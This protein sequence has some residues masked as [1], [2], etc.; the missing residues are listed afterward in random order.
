MQ[1]VSAKLR[2]EDYSDVFFEPREKTLDYR[3]MGS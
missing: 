2:E 3:K 1:E